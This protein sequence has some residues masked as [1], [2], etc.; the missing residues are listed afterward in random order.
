MSPSL[1]LIS[2]TPRG[3][4]DSASVS[5]RFRAVRQALLFVS[6]LASSLFLAGFS[7]TG[8]SS[9][10]DGGSGASGPSAASSTC[11]DGFQSLG[12]PGGCTPVLP[13]SACAAGTAPVIG[14][15][16]C[17]ATGPAQ[18]PAGFVP[19][20]S[21]WGCD[22]VIPSSAC[23][24]ATRDAV[25][26]AACVPV[27]DCGAAFPPANA[28]L[29]VDDSFTA[30]QLDATH[31]NTLTA[32]LAA[33][34]SGAVIAVDS[35]T[36]GDVMMAPSVGVSVVGRCAEQVVFQASDNTKTAVTLSND[37]PLAMSGI[38]F[39]DYHAAL[40]LLAGNVTLDSIVVEGS[41]YTGIAIGNV[42]TTAALDN[43]VV[44]GTRAGATDT[45][46]FGLYIGYG[47]K[48]TVQNSDFADNDYINV[49]VSGD[50]SPN[51]SLTLT[52]SVVRDG[53]A[54]G[55]QGG[56]G[57]GVYGV[58]KVT[59][60]VD[61][62]AIIDNHG[63]G[64]IMNSQSA[65]KN[66]ATGVVKSSVVRGTGYDP[67]N[68]QGIG[69]ES[70]QSSIDVEDSTVAASNMMDMY[71]AG[72]G[73]TKIVR[74]AFLGTSIPDDPSSLGPIGLNLN[75]VPATLQSVAFADTRVGAQFEG[76]T[77]AE[78]D[79]SIVAGT[80]TSPAGY[81]VDDNYVGVGMF[82]ESAA[83]LTINGSA[84]TGAHTAGLITLGQTT[85]SRLFV[86]GT[87]PG[88]DGSAGRAVS[89]QGS[90]SLTIDS[91]AF[92]DNTETGVLA[93]EDATLALTNSTIDQ[94]ALDSTGEFGIGVFIGDDDVVASIDR[95]TL[96]QSKGPA[97]AV[98]GSGATVTK[99]VV[100]DNA[101]G[102]AVLGGSSLV[103]GDS[104]GDPK[105][106]AISHDTV[107]A[108]NQTRVGSGDIP[109]PSALTTP[110]K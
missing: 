106:V 78:V 11:A 96:R 33:A 40:G 39:R 92:V 57:W 43:V 44:R 93:S 55:A 48:V 35:G 97:L 90:A 101:I 54:Y 18:C 67:A 95:A 71:A 32:A 62:S 104:N 16:D 13:A 91:S 21:G 52:S 64:V 9:S 66:F 85:A 98:S 22:V 56:F 47:A 45:T 25:G 42:K 1:P 10:S 103:E 68:K 79:D 12:D 60:T 7:L 30:G 46:S 88:G 61:S 37:V 69:I 100:V 51:A 99:S 23:T 80:R 50:G 110:K 84:I 8:C 73:A 24:G 2:P 82:V 19:N 89:A 41:H 29:F 63:F 72:G 28:T 49:G 3:R 5:D 76:A 87:R 4:L 109:L 36:Y 77:V 65:T 70:N 20:A 107:F 108:N 59:V 27:G 14:K 94:T 86:G 81:Y 17:V 6:G 15:T 83:Q 75:G 38:T 105:T 34:T 102:V 74:T 58:D 26:S 53:H 31:F